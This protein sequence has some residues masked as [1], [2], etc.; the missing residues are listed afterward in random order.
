MNYLAQCFPN[1]LK[2]GGKG[3]TP[4]NVFEGVSVGAALALRE[5]PQLEVCSKINWI[6]SIVF[7]GYTTSATNSL[8]KVKGRIDY[9]KKAFLS[10]GHIEP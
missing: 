4:A 2:R 5:C 8:P 6:D 7:R 3:S 10:H 9:A 1:G